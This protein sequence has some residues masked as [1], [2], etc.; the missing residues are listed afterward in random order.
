MSADTSGETRRGNRPQ[1]DRRP[2]R[3]T[4]LHGGFQGDAERLN[5]GGLSG[6]SS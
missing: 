6:I 2:L 1:A 3:T 5:A 4:V